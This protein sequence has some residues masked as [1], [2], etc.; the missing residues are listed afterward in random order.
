[1]LS[2]ANAAT[3]QQPHAVSGKEEPG[4][5]STVTLALQQPD[6]AFFQCGF[7]KRTYTRLDHLARHVR[8]RKLINPTSIV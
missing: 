8:S 2:T 6:P 1:M 7:C 3:N 4:N 5:T